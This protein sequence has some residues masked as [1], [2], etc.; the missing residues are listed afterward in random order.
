MISL[1]TPITGLAQTGLTTPTYTIT[2]DTASSANAK[3]WAVTAL[4][5]TQTGVSSHSVANPFTCAFVR[6]LNF[7]ANGTI[8]PATGLIRQVA[9]NS[10]KVITRKGTLP[11]AGQAPVTTIITTTIDV[12]AGADIADPNSVRAALSMHLGA[13]SQASASLGDT[14]VTGIL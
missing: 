8:N 1:S 4:G 2:V 6:P 11:L 12:V 14:V 9:K 5:G 7:K 10:F 3:Q 13:L